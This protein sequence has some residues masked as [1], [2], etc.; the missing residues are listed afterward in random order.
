VVIVARSLLERAG[1]PRADILDYRSHAAKESM[2]NTP[3]TWNWYLLG[4]T[5]RWM[6]DEGGV[7]EFARRNARKARM[8]Y[9]AIDGSGGFYRNEVAAAVRS[10]MNVPFFLHDDALD[11]PF[12][13][14][15]HEA[16]LISLKGHRA[17]GGMRAS[18]YNAM[19]EPGVQALVDFMRDFASRH[20]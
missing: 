10:R 8:L 5:V 1:Q 2:L 17:L 14:E 15:A 3:P 12:L 16:G 18:I 6:L 11:K 4:L 9:G 19:P 20:G 7:D 13:A